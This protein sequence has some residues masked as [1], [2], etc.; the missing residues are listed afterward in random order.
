[1]VETRTS[2]E[3][4][5]LEA[6]LILAALVPSVDHVTVAASVEAPTAVVAS[7]EDLDHMVVDTPEVAAAA[8][9][10]T[11]ADVAKAATL[12]LLHFPYA[13]SGSSAC[14]DKRPEWLCSRCHDR[15]LLQSD[16]H[17]LS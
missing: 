10:D 14:D 5:V 1:M 9:E 11:S 3:A 4:L 7:V 13:E 12:A 8:V 15:Q 6:V 2:A 16:P 17:S